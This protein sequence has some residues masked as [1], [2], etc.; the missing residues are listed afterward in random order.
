M[1]FLSPL[2]HV[3]NNTLQGVS[4]YYLKAVAILTPKTLLRLVKSS[5]MRQSHVVCFHV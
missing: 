5:V 2:L 4:I 1:L 3:T